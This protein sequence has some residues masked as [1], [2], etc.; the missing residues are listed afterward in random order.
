MSWLTDD[1][2]SRLRSAEATFVKALRLRPDDARAHGHFGSVCAVTKRV[3]RGVSEC[4]RALAIDRNCVWAHVHIG[5]AKYILGRN[6]ETEAHI[7]DALRLSPR[8]RSTGVGF[9]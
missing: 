5:M 3:D 7:L 2:L 9:R 4:E 1:R 8:D 6:D